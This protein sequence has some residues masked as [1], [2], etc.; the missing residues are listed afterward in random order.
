MIEY[1]RLKNKDTELNT[2]ERLMF[3]E[4]FITYIT[5]R[6]TRSNT[7]L[8]LRFYPKILNFIRLI[9]LYIIEKNKLWNIVNDFPESNLFQKDQKN[10]I[11]SSLI[12]LLYH[13]EILITK[14][15]HF[16]FDKK[17]RKIN[18]EQKKAILSVIEN[19]S[20]IIPK[21][22]S[23]NYLKMIKDFLFIR[24][25]ISRYR[26]STYKFRYIKQG[27]AW[28]AMLTEGNLDYEVR[29]CETLFHLS[30]LTL[31]DKIP[32]PFDESYYT[33][34]GRNAFNNFTKYRFGEI[35]E[36]I[37]KTKPLSSLLDIG[38]GYGNYLSVAIEKLNTTNLTGIELQKKVFEE[39]RSRFQDFSNVQIL[40]ID[41]F[42]FNSHQKFDLVLLNYVLFYFN[43]H[44]KK[45]LF[46][47]IAALLSED[48]T[49][50]LCQYFQGIENLKR[51]LAS[52]KNE[53][54]VSKKIEMFY[55]NKILYAN[56]LWNDTADTFSESAIWSELLEILNESNLVI[57]SVINA[58]SYY[59]S[60]FVAIKK[61]SQV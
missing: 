38:C 18:S 35:I 31:P 42:D 11:L 30:K 50:I 21:N 19:D 40:N 10:R 22:I 48:G 2:P 8:K 20:M 12:N 37:N 9:S 15:N 55:G 28:I 60:L 52:K 14:D 23:G 41:F 53:L 49:I 57:H 59:F 16:L 1:C 44:D 45:R 26:D 46:Q 58:D 5:K 56:T 43:Y 34:S 51:D 32:S 3:P 7:A 33:E 4:C 61:K 27:K 29:L 13:F 47:K 36:E 17:Y 24:D 54:S 25:L 6:L 39:T